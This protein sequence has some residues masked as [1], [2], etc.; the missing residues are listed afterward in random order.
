MA[1]RTPP[2]LRDE[3]GSAKAGFPDSTLEPFNALTVQRGET[4]SP[5]NLGSNS[6]Q[7]LCERTNKP[8]KQRND[9]ETV[10]SFHIDD[11]IDRPFTLASRY[12]PGH[13]GTGPFRNC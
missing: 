2:R 13:T 7:Y 11:T 10:Y 1:G 3:G 8:T 4:N 9:Y 6:G 5:R 12:L